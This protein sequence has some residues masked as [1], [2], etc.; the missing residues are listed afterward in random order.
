MKAWSPQFTLTPKSGSALMEIEA[1]KTLVDSSP[2]PLAASEELRRRAR[3]RAVHLSTKMAGNR[4]TLEEVE[5]IIFD[6]ERSKPP[7]RLSAKHR[8]S[9]G[10]KT[11][12]SGA[13]A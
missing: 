12:R 13:H 4:L 11:K 7:R 8:Q 2:L 6:H 3:L 5:R 9:I 10:N 1:A